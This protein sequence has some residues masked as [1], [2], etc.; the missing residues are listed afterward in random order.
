MRSDSLESPFVDPVPS[1]ASTITAVVVL[2]RRSPAESDALTSLLRVLREEPT[3][4]ARFSVLVYDNSPQ[5]QAS[6]LPS[7]PVAYHHDPAN[8]GL[9]S[10]YN[11]ALAQAEAAGTPWLLLLDQDTSLAAAFLQELASLSEELLPSK[12]VAAIVPKLFS[13]GTMYS[14][15]EHSLDQLH[16][17]FPHRSHT[18]PPGAEGPQSARISAYN[19]G[20]TLR[21]AALLAI[22]GFPREFWLDYLDHAVFHALQQQGSRVFVMQAVLEQQLSHG[23][24][25]TFLS[26]VIAM[27]SPRSPS[28]SN[29]SA[30]SGSAFR[31]GSSCCNWP[32]SPFAN[33][34]SGASGLS[35]WSSPH[36]SSAGL[37]AC[38]GGTLTR[39]GIALHSASLFPHLRRALHLQWR[40][41]SARAARQHA[42]PDAPAG[43]AHRLR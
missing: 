10:A 18:L 36:C 15:E 21:V 27:Y 29:A 43:R 5:D 22:G 14:P 41:L 35:R 25:T 34:A 6:S 26:G 11:Y 24:L 31:T 9:A 28:S 19:S 3:L 23:D 1:A 16:H 37:C 7:F 30:P 13:R 40:T 42:Y 12:N 8:G 2:Y 17:V 4:A 39:R 33:A 32:V 38:P 20:S